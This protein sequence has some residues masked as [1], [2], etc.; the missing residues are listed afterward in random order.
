MIQ[1]CSA[2]IQDSLGRVFLQKR[3]QGSR[4]GGLFETP[5]GKI[6]PGETSA[7]ALARELAEEL[8]ITAADVNPRPML[9]V[10]F[11]EP[12][13]FVDFTVHFHRVLL[14]KDC[15]PISTENASAL[16]F[17]HLQYLRDQD[18]M[19]SLLSLRSFLKVY[20]NQN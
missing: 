20:E 19:S 5:G 10:S 13:V 11:Y 17:Y 7:V 6:E 2:V 9:S 4:F 14:D 1:V 18:C 15:V 8:A 16:G 3:P 12:F